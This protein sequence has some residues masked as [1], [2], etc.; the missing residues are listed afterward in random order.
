MAIPDVETRQVLVA[1]YILIDG[2]S[3]CFW[4]C[5]R[6]CKDFPFRHSEAVAPARVGEYKLDPPCWL[7]PSSVLGATRSCYTRKSSFLS[8]GLPSWVRIRLDFNPQLLPP[9]SFMTTLR[10]RH[11]RRRCPWS[12]CL[13]ARVYYETSNRYVDVV[14]FKD[15]LFFPKDVFST[16]VVINHIESSIK[17]RYIYE[18]IVKREC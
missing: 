1:M 3:A 4:F 15:T 16:Y 2:G 7:T 5:R 17:I 18:W 9:I 6:A 11:T 14:A 8:H 10:R 12:V 13:S